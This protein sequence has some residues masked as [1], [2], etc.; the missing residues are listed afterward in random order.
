VIQ[1]D[2]GVTPGEGVDFDPP[3]G[4]RGNVGKTGKLFGD[5]HPYFDQSALDKE[6]IERNA[7][8][9]H[10]K[11][12]RGEVREHFREDKFEMRLPQLQMPV[13]MTNREVKQVT[14]KSHREAPMRNELLYVLAL[15]ADRLQY[16]GSSPDNGTH[17]QVRAWHYYSLTAGGAEFVIHIW[18]LLLD[19]GETRLGIARISEG[20]RSVRPE[21]P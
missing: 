3:K 13:R 10:A 19:S 12:T 9:L 8:S 4:F 5:D 6:R 14:G 17:P 7:K 21:P 15:F 16:L 20:L 1:T 11:L 2:E 18:N